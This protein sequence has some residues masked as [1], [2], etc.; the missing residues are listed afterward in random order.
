MHF[1]FFDKM[2]LVFILL[3]ASLIAILNAA[4]P[5]EKIASASTEELAPEQDYTYI[6]PPLVDKKTRGAL[7]LKS[8]LAFNPSVHET[9]IEIL[10][11]ELEKQIINDER[12]FISQEELRIQEIIK[13]SEFIEYQKR[14]NSIDQKEELCHMQDVLKKKID[15]LVKIQR[16]LSKQYFN[17]ELIQEWGNIILIKEKYVKYMQEEFNATMNVLTILSLEKSV[18]KIEAKQGVDDKLPI[19][20]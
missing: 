7:L 9:A 19:M 2:N 13:L 3:Q 1:D 15:Q 20:D 10:D 18:T 14:Y 12:I 16:D 8:I 6:N 5:S 11:R 17:C 4:E